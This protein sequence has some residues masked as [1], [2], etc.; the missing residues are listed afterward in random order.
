MTDWNLLLPR[1][2]WESLTLSLAGGLG[3]SL[4]TLGRPVLISWVLICVGECTQG[5]GRNRKGGGGE[6][7][8]AYLIQGLLELTPQGASPAQGLLKS[9]AHFRV[10]YN[11]HGVTQKNKT[12]NTYS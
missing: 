3:G 9:E 1:S 2:H 7:H 11:M 5:G 6:S 8:R 10:E 12:V 4:L